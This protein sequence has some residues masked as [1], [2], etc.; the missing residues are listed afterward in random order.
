MAALLSLL[1]RNTGLEPTLFCMKS[2]PSKTVL[3]SESQSQHRNLR[4]HKQ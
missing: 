4:A 3:Q 1:G 2:Q